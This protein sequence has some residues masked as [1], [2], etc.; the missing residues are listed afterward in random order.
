[1]RVREHAPTGKTDCDRFCGHPASSVAWAAIPET[2][3]PK[4]RWD[5][6][7]AE[8]KA[9]TCA[10]AADRSVPSRSNISHSSGPSQSAAL[11]PSRADVFGRVGSVRP[12][13]DD[14]AATLSAGA[15]S[16]TRLAGAAGKTSTQSWVMER[17]A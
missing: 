3:I 5:T 9:S 4:L 16:E 12:N 13:A 6:S 17:P 14:S 1:N 10:K 8:W 15:R 2:V 11:S 7:T